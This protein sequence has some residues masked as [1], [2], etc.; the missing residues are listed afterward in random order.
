MVDEELVGA[1][2]GFLVMVPLFNVVDSVGVDAEKMLA[3]D[4]GFD[5]GGDVGLV[6]GG[7]VDFGFDLG[8]D[9]GLVLGGD[10]D[11]GFDLGGDVGLVLG[12][13]VDF[14]FGS[15]QADFGDLIF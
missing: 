13:D 5:L 12:G 15:G 4:F 10:V 6:F 8:G 7:D 1:E 2:I 11:F 9:V 14:G 3:F